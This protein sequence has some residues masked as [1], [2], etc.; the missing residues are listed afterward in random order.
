M[1]RPDEFPT[2]LRDALAS[3]TTTLIDVQVR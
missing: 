1:R 2:A 3:S